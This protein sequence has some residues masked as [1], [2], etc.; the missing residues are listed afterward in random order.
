[1][2][3]ILY[4]NCFIGLNYNF[5]AK[6]I[7]KNLSRLQIATNF[8]EGEYYNNFKN[9]PLSNNSLLPHQQIKILRVY[10]ITNA[11]VC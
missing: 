6:K 10:Y 7:E 4:T 5:Y 2:M 1:M 3:E 9:M 11:C 8:L